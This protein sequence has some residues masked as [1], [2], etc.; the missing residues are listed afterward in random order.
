V[1]DVQ[2]LSKARAVKIAFGNF[3]PIA[4]APSVVF[5]K[6]GFSPAKLVRAKF[7]PG[8]AVD[9]WDEPTPHAATTQAPA[10]EIGDDV[11]F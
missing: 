3:E 7:T 1:W 5:G 4:L 10:D 9:R 11:P 6:K 8:A 2:G